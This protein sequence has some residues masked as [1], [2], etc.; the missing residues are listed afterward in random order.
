MVGV[1]TPSL[2]GRADATLVSCSGIRSTFELQ[3]SVA[4][5]L[6]RHMH[7]SLPIPDNSRRYEFDGTAY[8]KKARVERQ[9]RSI[10]EL[11]LLWI[12]SHDGARF[13]ENHARNCEWSRR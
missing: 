2:T 10:D 13:L 7:T 5:H 4:G 6:S 3:R 1:P 8:V 12:E 9:G 11:S